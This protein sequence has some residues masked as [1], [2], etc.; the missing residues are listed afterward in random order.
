MNRKNYFFRNYFNWRIARI[1]TS[2]RCYFSYIFEVPAWQ[3][4]NNLRASSILQL[5]LILLI[6]RCSGKLW[7]CSREIRLIKVQTRGIDIIL[8]TS[9]SKF[10]LQVFK[11][12]ID[13][14][15]DTVYWH[16]KVYILVQRTP[17]SEQTLDRMLIED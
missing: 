12:A 8:E 4:V 6:G 10:S 2:G 16:L 15:M 9:A 7:C 13:W 11:Y 17:N 1:F 5:L 14:V 3:S